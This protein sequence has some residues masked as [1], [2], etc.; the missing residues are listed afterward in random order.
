[1]AAQM[2]ARGHA[3]VGEAHAARR[4]LGEAEELIR[5]AGEHSED[6][7]P[8]MYLY[9]DGW[10]DMQR[11]MAELALGDGRRAVSFLNRGLATLP[12]AYRRDRA[13]FGTCLARAHALAGDVE[14]A[15]K[16]AVALAPDAV[17]VNRY[18]AGDLRLLATSLR[19]VRPQ[20]GERIRDALSAPT[21]Q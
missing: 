5:T 18:A 6:E 7:P 10:F 15:E 8:W 21:R 14:A 16:L 1:M 20:S 3:E 2:A 4:L 17:A 19:T 11:G 13:W 12:S 9:D